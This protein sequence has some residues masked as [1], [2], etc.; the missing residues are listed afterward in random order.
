M[1]G[2]LELCLTLALRFCRPSCLLLL[3][4]LISGEVE[5]VGWMSKWQWQRVASFE[6]AG[7]QEKWVSSGTGENQAT[8]T[9]WL[10]RCSAG[11]RNWAWFK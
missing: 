6:T 2:E 7:V 9:K 5:A 4:C 1:G 10:P 3:F 8:S 11:R